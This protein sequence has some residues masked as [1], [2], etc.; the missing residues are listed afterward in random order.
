MKQKIGIRKLVVED[1]NIDLSNMLIN[2]RYTKVWIKQEFYLWNPKKYHFHL[3]SS[4]IR[5]FT[6]I[7]ADLEVQCSYYLLGSRRGG[8]LFFGTWLILR[9][10][11]LP[12]Y[13]SNFSIVSFLIVYLSTN[14][15]PLVLLLCNCSVF[16]TSELIVLLLQSFSFQCSSLV[17]LF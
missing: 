10:Y 14:R 4:L 3:S 8:L 6:V 13:L 11:H 5:S 1:E 17:R 7:S 2:A 12:F 15:Q 16:D 9:I